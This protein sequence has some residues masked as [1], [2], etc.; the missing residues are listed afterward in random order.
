MRVFDKQYLASL[1]DRALN[2]SKRDHL[3]LHGSFGQKVQ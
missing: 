3:N 2:S 1:K